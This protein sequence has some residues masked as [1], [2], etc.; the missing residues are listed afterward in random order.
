LPTKPKLFKCPPFNPQDVP[1]RHANFQPEFTGI[2]SAFSASF[3]SEKWFLLV[4]GQHTILKDYL[5]AMKTGMEA[6]SQLKIHLLEVSELFD[7]AN[8]LKAQMNPVVRK[9]RSVFNAYLVSLVWRKIYF[10]R[11]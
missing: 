3:W 9:H 1:S 7:K 8:T 5:E 4:T 2:H 6:K 10:T 11:Q